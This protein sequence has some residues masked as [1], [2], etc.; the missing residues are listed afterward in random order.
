MKFGIIGGTSESKEIAIFMY[1]N[2]IDFNIH[3]KNL[4]SSF[5]K[6]IIK[7]EIKKIE[8]LEGKIVGETIE[9]K[10]LYDFL[11]DMSHP[12]AQNIKKLYKDIPENKVIKFCRKT[13][14]YDKKFYDIDS[15]VLKIIEKKHK[16]ILSLMGFKGTN[17]FIESVSKFNDIKE[18]VIVSRSIEKVDFGINYFF[19]PEKIFDAEWFDYVIEKHAI[20]CV[21]LKDSGEQSKLQEKLNFFS[22]KNIEIIILSY[23]DE[24]KKFK[25]FKE[26]FKLKEYILEKVEIN[27]K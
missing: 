26:I 16:N 22:K 6:N 5:N 2:N 23:K 24:L 25:R 7:S 11:I 4:Y 12:F 14:K 13:S 3:F 18:F 10:Y 1:E 17:I 20:S 15:I 27:E 9:K 21:L 19:K 8:F